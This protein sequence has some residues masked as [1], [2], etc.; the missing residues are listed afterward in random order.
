MIDFD[1]FLPFVSFVL[2][3]AWLF[4]WRE[5]IRTFVPVSIDKDVSYAIF[6][7][8]PARPF[9]RCNLSPVKTG[10]FL[11]KFKIIVIVTMFSVSGGM[12]NAESSW[13]EMSQFEK[14]EYYFKDWLK[15]FDMYFV[16][17]NSFI[18]HSLWSRLYRNKD[19]YFSHF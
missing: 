19:G 16:T 7:F 15:Y 3:M 10:K 6:F 8:S 9:L 18:Y 4:N 12:R 14:G 5:N 2:T 13:V 17:L 11:L 1:K